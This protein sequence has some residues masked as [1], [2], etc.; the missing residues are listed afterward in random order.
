MNIVFT[1][2]IRSPASWSTVSRYLL[3]EFSRL[4]MQVR[5]I[6]KRGFLYKKDFPSDRVI[7]DMLNIN[8]DPSA[9]ISLCFDHPRFYKDLMGNVK[10]G[11]L[12]YETLP[13]PESWVESI[14][15]YLDIVFVPNEINKNIFVTSGVCPDKIRIVP[16]GFDPHLASQPHGI[17][18]RENEKT[19]YLMIS[20]PHKRKGL[21]H[22]LRAFCRAF[23]SKDP[24][25]LTIKTTYSTKS[26]KS[27]R[28]W[29][30][31]PVKDMIK[32]IART[33]CNPPEI[34]ANECCLDDPS[35]YA[36]YKNFDIYV[37]PGFAEGFGL[38]V[39]EAM[40]CGLPCIVTGHGGYM[41]FCH[42]GTCLLLPYSLR[43]RQGMAYETT[44]AQKRIRV[45]VP[46]MEGTIRLLQFSFH[47][48]DAMRQL[49][50]KA[51]KNIRHLT[52]SHSAQMI[53]KYLEEESVERAKV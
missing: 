33:F 42:E 15:R 27:R 4:N 1:G 18:C 29:E 38:A 10:A 50:A 45:A 40:A 35:M 19:R 28:P 46:N 34:M 11:L 32:R 2:L 37:Q 43:Y 13:L 8:I 3:R 30:T 20:M 12:V 36:Y 21:A 53:Q 14:N 31:E 16:Y 7:E 52:W 5:L 49:S 48:P 6:P 24:V 26:R 51:K 23:T 44:L 41:D 39:L 47:N 17:K 25:S 22:F 9:S